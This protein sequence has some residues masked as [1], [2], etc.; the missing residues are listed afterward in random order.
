MQQDIELKL[1]ESGKEKEDIGKRM[2]LL[3][4]EEAALSYQTDEGK[5]V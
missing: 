3:L 5:R 1:K 2:E 4:L